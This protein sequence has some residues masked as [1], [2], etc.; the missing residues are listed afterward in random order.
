[1]L[2]PYQPLYLKYRPQSLADLVGQSS[3]AQSLKNAIEHD[4]ISHAYLFTGPRGCGKTSSARILA[5]SINCDQGMTATPCLKCTSCDEVRIGNS[6][7]VIEIDAASNNSVDDARLLIERAPLVAQNGKHKLYIIDECHMLTTGAFNALLKT[8]EEPPPH[9]IFILA[10]TEEHKVPHTIMSRCQRLM[11]RLVN[12]PE[13]VAHLKKIAQAEKIEI[14]DDAI[15]LIARRSGGGLRDAL[16]LLDQA[17]LVAA[18]GKPATVKDLLTLLGAVHEDVL[19]QI[20][21]AVLEHD[22]GAALEAAHGLMMEGREPTQ[23][24]MELAKHFLNLAKASYLA[25][26]RSTKADTHSLILGSTSYVDGLIEQSPGFDRAELA[27]IVEQLDKLEQTCKRSSQPALNLEVSLV[28]L[29]H[30]QDI[31][32]LQDLSQRVAQM[33]AELRDGV[34]PPQSQ[35]GRPTAAPRP[36][37]AVSAIRPAERPAAPPRQVEEAKPVPAHQPAKPAD[38][39]P[40]PQESISTA[41]PIEEAKPAVPQAQGEETQSAPQPQAA[42]ATPLTAHI[43]VEETKFAAPPISQTPMEATSDQTEIDEASPETLDIPYDLTEDAPPAAPPSP[44]MTI[45]TLTE[46]DSEMDDSAAE[47]QPG[48]A[49]EKREPER[50]VPPI[51]AGFDQVALEEFWSNVKD[52]LHGRSLPLHAVVSEHAF[53][54]SMENN[55]CLTIGVMMSHFQKMIESRADA[56]KTA[57]EVVAGRPISV[58]VKLVDRNTTSSQ[59]PRAK[60]KRTAATADDANE[61]PDGAG[62]VAVASPPAIKPPSRFENEAAK[63]STTK[64]KSIASESVETPTAVS[65][66]NESGNPDRTAADSGLIAEAY[67]LFEGPGSRRILPS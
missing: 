4:R 55:D 46:A 8:I 60:A 40:A 51:T 65:S 61:E 38:A 29:C 63:V 32:L 7:S 24:A 49:T 41:Q 5:K 45:S 62:G 47:S 44:Q 23:L 15:E 48:P 57:C 17:S 27:Q 26:G 2:E 53:P 20:S 35:Q 1:M 18:P 58:K 59:R 19:L 64:E 3:V 56:M 13:L 25:A 12:Q 6:P 39:P 34:S 22:G 33:E 43:P 16:G 14:E 37:A 67:K 36:A 31:L 54:L 11:F 52:E 9:V 30:R 42:E 66:A 50:V 21:Q 28:A 10:T